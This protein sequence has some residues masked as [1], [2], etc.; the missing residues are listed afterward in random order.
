MNPEIPY[1]GDKDLL[2]R[3]KRL[4]KAISTVCSIKSAQI[5]IY[6]IDIYG[7]KALHIAK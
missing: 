5:S 3:E 7:K 1:V 2:M 4:E 6:Y